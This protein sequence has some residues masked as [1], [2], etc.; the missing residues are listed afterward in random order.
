METI[1]THYL[2]ILGLV[3]FFAAPALGFVIA[4][5]QS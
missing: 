1:M 2:D 3:A 5:V 4:I